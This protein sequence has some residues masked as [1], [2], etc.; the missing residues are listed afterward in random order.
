LNNDHKNLNSNYVIYIIG[1]SATIRYEF[2]KK[3]VIYKFGSSTYL[4]IQAKLFAELKPFQGLK[5]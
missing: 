1:N 3:K 4:T 2:I 5:T